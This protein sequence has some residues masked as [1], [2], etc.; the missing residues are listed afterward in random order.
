MIALLSPEAHQRRFS[1]EDYR[2]AFRHDQDYQ[3]YLSADGMVTTDLLQSCHRRS[4]MRAWHANRLVTEGRLAFFLGIGIGAVAMR[5]W[6][7]RRRR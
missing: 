5:A 3:N 2:R 7:H 1:E 6:M 4:A